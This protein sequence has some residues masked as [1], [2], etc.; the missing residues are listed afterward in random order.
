MTFYYRANGTHFVIDVRDG[1]SGIFVRQSAS[2]IAT[3]PSVPVYRG[4]P[5]DGCTSC[6]GSGVELGRDWC[7]D[8]RWSRCLC[9]RKPPIAVTLKQ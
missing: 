9:V 2:D 6:G 7:G 8:Q 5:K 4:T 3:A 1:G